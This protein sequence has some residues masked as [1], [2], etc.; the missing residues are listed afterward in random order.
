MLDGV[1]NAMNVNERRDSS[2]LKGATRYAKRT[3]K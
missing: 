3:F 1:R 2:A